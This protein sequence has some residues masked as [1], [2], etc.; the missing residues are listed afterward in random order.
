MAKILIARF[1]L[2]PAL[3]IFLF[4]VTAFAAST[5][6][7][8]LSYQWLEQKGGRFLRAKLKPAALEAA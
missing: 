4:G 7:S 1:G 6:V 8:W 2:P 5:L 3:A